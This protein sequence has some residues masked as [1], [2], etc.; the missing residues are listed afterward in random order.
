VGKVKDIP[1]NPS[2][3]IKIGE[4]RMGNNVV[5]PMDGFS[6]SYN[7]NTLVFMPKTPAWAQQVPSVETAL[8]VDGKFYIL[9]GNH[10]EEYKKLGTLKKCMQ[11]FNEHEKE[12]SVWSD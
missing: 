1:E 7:P 4:P 2:W 9:N 8:L 11:Y 3:S 12:K 6:I 5:T 10:V